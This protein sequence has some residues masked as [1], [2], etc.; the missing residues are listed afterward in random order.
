M[1][2]FVNINLMNRFNSIEISCRKIAGSHTGEV[3]LAEYKDIIKKYQIG[4]KI[5]MVLFKYLIT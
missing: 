1:I 5:V 2:T 4:S 3:I